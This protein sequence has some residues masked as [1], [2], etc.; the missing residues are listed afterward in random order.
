MELFF[1]IL[2]VLAY[3]TLCFYLIRKKAFGERYTK[4][5]SGVALLI[6]VWCFGSDA[7]FG[8][9]LILTVLGLNTLRK[10][11]LYFRKVGK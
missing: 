1:L 5:L 10:E 9:K 8:P 3:L 4:I 11:Y 6:L 2:F 7:P